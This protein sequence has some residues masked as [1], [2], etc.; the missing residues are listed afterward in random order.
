M[1]RNLNGRVEAMTPVTDA[2][3]KNRLEE[4][5]TILLDDTGAWAMDAGGESWRRTSTDLSSSAQTR[6]QRLA[7]ER[8]GTHR[9][10]STG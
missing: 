4:I 6:L 5:L 1:P 8:A 10:R 9:A 7:V 3:L 2:A